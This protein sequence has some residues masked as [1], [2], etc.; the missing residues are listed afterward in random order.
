MPG[1]EQAI[2]KVALLP[3]PQFWALLDK[4]KAPIWKLCGHNRD[5]LKVIYALRRD[6]GLWNKPPPKT[7]RGRFEMMTIHLIYGV[8]WDEQGC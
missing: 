4:P 1:I 3:D 7:T 5:L 8:M 6:A 2:R